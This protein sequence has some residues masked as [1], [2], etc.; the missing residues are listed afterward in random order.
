[1]IA[2]NVKSLTPGIS[3]SAFSSKNLNF[4]SMFTTSS[5][6]LTLKIWGF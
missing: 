5:K 4:S 2:T 1:L 6:C 3:A